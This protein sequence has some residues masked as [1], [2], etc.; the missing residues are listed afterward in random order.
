MSK[1]VDETKEEYDARRAEQERQRRQTPEWQEKNREYRQQPEILAR[2][3]EQERERRKTKQV[4]AYNREYRREYRDKNREKFREYSREFQKRRRAALKE[5]GLPDPYKPTPER[6]REFY[7]AW[8]RKNPRHTMLQRSKHTAKSRGFEW[9]LTMDDIH[10]PTHCPVLGIELQ[11]D[12][13]KKT[14]HRDDYPSFDRWD[15][16]KGYVPGNVF[17]IS[18]RANRIKWNCTL[19]ELR[20]VADY[21]EFGLTIS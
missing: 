17:V 16:T 1:R 7:L 12:R 20:A 21:T 13:N 11:Y 19:A 8:E 9:N 2:H 6:Q 15:G 18:W 5:S 10:W 14:P 3:A 4:K